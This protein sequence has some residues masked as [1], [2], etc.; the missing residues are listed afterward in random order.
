MDNSTAEQDPFSEM[1]PEGLL[2][3][4]G[5]ED[6]QFDEHTEDMDMEKSATI[7]SSTLRVNHLTGQ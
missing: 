3:N 6:A 4:T 2:P 5:E 1:D 7:H